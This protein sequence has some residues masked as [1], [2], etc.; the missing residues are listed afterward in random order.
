MSKHFFKTERTA[1]YQVGGNTVNPKKMWLAVHGYGQQAKY[2]ERKI[3]ALHADDTIVVTPEGLN[4]YY[5]EGFKG[6]VGATWMTSDDREVDIADNNKYLESLVAH[7]K[8]QYPSIEEINVL[9]FS[10]GV[11]TSCR[12]YASSQ[13]KVNKLLLWAGSLAHDLNFTQYQNRF[14]DSKIYYIFGN[15][16]EFFDAS[17][18]LMN[19]YKLMNADIE[20]QLV[21]FEGKHVIDSAMLKQLSHD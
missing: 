3:D 15:Q 8:V 21:S 2:F 12:W 17:K 13:F 14:L 19:E 6:R 5:L 9:A 7:I 16:D 1:R 20:Y 4:R 11:A 10:Q 18:I